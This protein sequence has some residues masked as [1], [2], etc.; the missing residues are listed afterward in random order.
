M[1]LCSLNFTIIS[2][3]NRS[4]QPKP[5]ATP[6]TSANAGTMAKSRAA[7]IEVIHDLDVKTANLQ[8]FFSV[9]LAAALVLAKLF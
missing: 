2:P 4:S 5:L 8:L 3:F 1:A 6:T 7:G 9:L